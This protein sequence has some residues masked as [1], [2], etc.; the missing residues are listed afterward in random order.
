MAAAA[1]ER[2]AARLLASAENGRARDP[3]LPLIRPSGRRE[4]CE[5]SGP[6]DAPASPRTPPVVRH[7]AAAVDR[8]ATGI[9]LLDE[10][11]TRRS[12]RWQPRLFSRPCDGGLAF[13]APAPRH[14]WDTVVTNDRPAMITLD[15]AMRALIRI[16]NACET[17]KSVARR[18]SRA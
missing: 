8:K 4:R 17:Q 6:P 2:V 14:A 13:L 12:L 5:R 10:A 15:G 9:V 1:E 11:R 16:I 3:P 18:A 7:I